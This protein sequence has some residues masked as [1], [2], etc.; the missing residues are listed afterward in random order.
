MLDSIERER[1]CHTFEDA[2]TLMVQ[3]KTNF[4]SSLFECS[5]ALSPR[6][7]QYIVSHFDCSPIFFFGNSLGYLMYTPCLH[8]VVP[9]H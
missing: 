8:K 7:I 5:C 4:T 2:E 9:L 3:L 6:D 1:N